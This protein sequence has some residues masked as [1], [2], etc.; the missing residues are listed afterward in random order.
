MMNSPP[1]PSQVAKVR[2]GRRLAGFPI[3]RLPFARQ[4]ATL[5]ASEHHFRGL[6]PR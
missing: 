2:N 5:H 3:D 4:A 6:L 1:H